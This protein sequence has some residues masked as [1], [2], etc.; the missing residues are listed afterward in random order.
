MACRLPPPS[1]LQRNNWKTRSIV[2]VV[3]TRLAM[4]AVAVAS[5]G[6]AA[7]GHQHLV[8]RQS[9]GQ[10]LEARLLRLAEERCGPR[11]LLRRGGRDQALGDATSDVARIERIKTSGGPS[12][13]N[14]I[15]GTGGQLSPPRS[16]QLDECFY[17]ARVKV[18]DATKAPVRHTEHDCV[19]REG[20]PAS[21]ESTS[22]RGT[23]QVQHA[24]R[25]D[26]PQPSIS[27]SFVSQ[28]IDVRAP[29]IVL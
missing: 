14:M 19:E 4:A 6:A 23:P 16:P 9:L 13:P 15:C 1:H 25:S 18:A 8:E 5:A 28:Q 26:R 24:G 17:V 21:A 3:L 11:P 22:S 10:H 20:S 29:L 27:A 7:G 2:D 12:F